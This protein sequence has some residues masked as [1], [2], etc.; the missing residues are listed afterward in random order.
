MNLAPKLLIDVEGQNRIPGYGIGSELE[1]VLAG[2]NI[3][4]IPEN[5]R[6]LKIYKLLE[7][8]CGVIFCTT[9][10]LEDFKFYPVPAFWIFALDHDGNCFGT[11]GGMGGIVDSNYPVGYV[12]INGTYGKLA[13]NL[14]QFLELVTFYPY[15]RDII[16]CEELGISYDINTISMKRTEND[17]QY[18]EYQSEI[19][20]TLRLSK[21]PRSI[22]LLKLNINS[23][24]EFIVYDS[25]DEAGMKNRFF[26]IHSPIK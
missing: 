17:L 24:S 4:P 20:E 8:N 11:I 13:N 25:K 9:Q 14:K 10:K 26:D 23:E 19:A 22:E 12:N 1:V 15:W 5:E 6:N 2:K 21:N 3:L 16:K 18:L 7:E